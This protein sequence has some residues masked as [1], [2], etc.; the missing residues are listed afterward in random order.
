MLKIYF[1]LLHDSYRLRSPPFT[2]L[3]PHEALAK[4]KKQAIILLLH[5]RIATNVH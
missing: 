1:Y 2:D 3:A 5:P 4:I